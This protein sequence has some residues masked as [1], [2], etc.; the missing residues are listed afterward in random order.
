MT[1][2]EA[3]HLCKEYRVRGTGLGSSL[4]RAVDD[5]SLIVK[6]GET[7]AL[8]GESGSGKSTMAKMLIRLIDPTSGSILLDGSPLQKGRVAVKQYRSRV[9]MVFQDPFSSLNPSLP[10]R[11]QLSRPLRIHGIV[12]TKSEEERELMRLMDAVNL[13]PAKTILDKYPH[14]LSGGQRQ[15]VAIARALAPQPEVL[16]ADEPVSMLDV[17]IRLEILQLLDDLKVQRNLAVL[18]IT[19][20]LAT[21]RHFSSQIVVMRTGRVVER[22]L[23]DD[24]I[25]NPIHPYTQLLVRAAP[26]PKSAPFVVDAERYRSH[27]EVTIGDVDPDITTW[28]VDS[29]WARAWDGEEAVT[30]LLGSVAA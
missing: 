23:S 24:V 19:H 28:P 6:P 22:G 8:V 11:H 13:A 18:Y 21:A 1:T 29:H 15:R 14:E 16:I 12:R 30:K 5:V 9:Q 3:L 2:L 20:D 7:V 27:P 4:L 17:S 10:I 26:D 25:M